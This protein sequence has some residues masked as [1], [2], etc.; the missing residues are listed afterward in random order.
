MGHLKIISLDESNLLEC[1]R[2]RR[3]PSNLAKGELQQMRFGGFFD[4]YDF[5]SDEHYHWGVSDGS[6]L[7]AMVSLAVGR[8]PSHTVV[9]MSDF[10]SLP[11]S[12][13]RLSSRKL[14][15]RVHEFVETLPGPVALLA[16]ESRYRLLDPLV[17]IAER[18]GFVFKTEQILQS[19]AVSCASAGGWPAAERFSICKLTESSESARQSLANLLGA[20]LSWPPAA[21]LIERTVRIDSKAQLISI[22]DEISSSWAILYSERAYRAY[23]AHTHMNVIA[24]DE[25]LIAAAAELAGKGGCDWL[26][27]RQPFPQLSCD[28]WPG[29]V[30][31]F[32]RVLVGFRA[33]DRDRFEPLGA[34]L[35]QGMTL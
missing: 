5:I 31:F 10:F 17:A 26:L 2:L 21:S 13:Q 11:E 20:D 18:F 34:H 24:S 32:N 28:T 4:Y 1:E 14:I 27:M 23:E 33:S 3:H 19:V 16:I 22:D 12:R 9:L 35:F 6:T 15:E 8:S 29:C 7:L 25:K 30:N